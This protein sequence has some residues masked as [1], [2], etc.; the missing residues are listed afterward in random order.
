MNPAPVL[1]QCCL[2]FQT[3]D[4][5]LNVLQLETAVGA[6]IKSFEGAIGAC[7]RVCVC[8]GEC[9]RMRVC[10]VCVRVCEGVFVFI[11]PFLSSLTPHA[12]TLP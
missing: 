4:N 2:T 11:R 10:G 12:S 3:L 5:G 7:V 6:A 8:S 1:Q 9:V